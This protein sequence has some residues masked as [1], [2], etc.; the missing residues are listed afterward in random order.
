[1]SIEVNL[2]PNLMADGPN[3]TS[4]ALRNA[5]PDNLY[6]SSP[7]STSPRLHMMRRV[8]KFLKSALKLIV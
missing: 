3:Q 8:G 1:M 6:L 5:K 2:S 7:S 4:Q